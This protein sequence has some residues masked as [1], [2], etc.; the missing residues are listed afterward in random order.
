MAIYYVDLEGG[1]D[2][3]GDGSNTAPYKTHSKAS[4][5]MSDNDELRLA[6]NT[7]ADTIINNVFSWS[8][9]S[10]IVTVEAD[11]TATLAEGDHIGKPTAAGNGAFETFYRI[12][13]VSYSTPTTTIKLYNRYYGTTEATAS[14]TKKFIQIDDINDCAKDTICSWYYMA[15]GGYGYIG[16]LTVSGGWNLTTETQDGE[17]WFTGTPPAWTTDAWYAYKHG[18]E[19]D[20]NNYSKLNIVGLS[21]P[22]GAHNEQSTLVDDCTFL[23]Y[24]GFLSFSQTNGGNVNNCVIFSSGG[25][26]MMEQTALEG[27][28]FSNIYANSSNNEAFYI[29]NPGNTTTFNDCVFVSAFIGMLMQISAQKIILNNTICSGGLEAISCE[30][31]GNQIEFKGTSE[32]THSIKGIDVGSGKYGIKISNPV[33]NNCTYGIVGSQIF[34]IL[35]DN[36]TAD[37]CDYAFRSDV[38]G[39]EINLH[40]FNYTNTKQWSICNYA[41]N[42]P[43]NLAGGTTDNMTN[44]IYN[45]A[46]DYQLP[47][48]RAQNISGLR[49]GVFWNS[50]RWQKYDAVFRTKAPS[51]WFSTDVDLSGSYYPDKVFNTY[52]ETGKAYK[53]SV[54][55][56]V[57]DL[58]WKGTV[59]PELRLN[60]IIVDSYPEK[61]V[62][63][64]DWEL[65]EFPM[66]AVSPNDGEL[67][68]NL[69]INQNVNDLFLDD[70]GV[71]EITI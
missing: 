55:V 13:S 12:E 38:Y 1:N 34:G 48:F 50:K 2:T 7:T 16:N 15:D 26:A 8:M 24:K 54:Y 71:E 30:I 66:S 6:K 32:V 3:T 9:A 4:A 61:T 25:R 14:A 36:H 60:G 29:S 57:G 69:T 70:F 46:P 44:L 10:D 40:G 33:T 43:M 56:K 28:S 23:V 18:D 27:K 65:W 68:L 17:T 58:S 5:Q 41:S 31:N 51:Y 45:P 20:P 37:S 47:K 19:T 49:D 64:S 35:I 59:L 11:L 22:F 39:R 42:C 62:I 67:S 63:S 52:A 53:I 21:E